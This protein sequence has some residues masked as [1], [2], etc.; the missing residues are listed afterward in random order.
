MNIRTTIICLALLLSSCL[1]FGQ[2][3]D[4]VLVADQYLQENLETLKLYPE[5]IEGYKVSSLTASKHNKATHLYL[6]QQY[7]GIEVFN[8]IFNL[9]IL[10]DG[11]VA[12]YGNRFLGQLYKRI[13]T[14]TPQISMEEA[15]KSFIRQFGI[16]SDAS[17]RMM[18]QISPTEATFDHVGLAL[19]PIQVKLVYQSLKNK[20]VHLAWNISFYQ[21]DAQHWWNARLDAID[22][23]V[24]HY[25][26]QVVHCEFGHMD[27][28]GEHHAI[29]AL[30]AAEWTTTVN[31]SDSAKYNV[32][33]LLVESPNHGDRALVVAPEDPLVSPFGWHDTD[34]EEGAEYTITRG[35]NVHA[36]HDIFSTNQSNGDEPDGGDSLC[37]DFELDLSVNRPY[38]QIDP[39]VTN[40]FYWNNLMHDVWYHYGFDEAS[41]NFQTTNYTGEGDGGDEVRAEAL[42]GSGTN[43]A[44]FAT[45]PEGSNPRMQ[46]Y[47]WGGQLPSFSGATFEVTSPDEVA[48]AY[49]FAPAGFGGDLPEGDDVLAGQV[50]L[51]DDGVGVTSDACDP[52]VNGAELEGNIAMIDRGECEFGFKCLAAEQAGAIAVIVCNNV[53]D[54]VFTMGAGAV[55]GQVTIP[56]IMVG[57]EDCNILKMGLPELTVEMGEPTL[58]VPQ[59]GPTGR[60]SDLDNGVIVHEYTHGISNRLTAG[61]QQS[62]CLSNF[63][64]AG[65]GWSDWYAL[66]MT[67]TS[68]MTAEQP[69]GI[70]TYASGQPPTGDGI[71]THPYSRDMDVNPHTFANIN[72][73][74]V[75]HGVGS[76]W[77]VMIWDLFWNLVDE[78]GYDEDL[79]YGTGGNNMAMQLVTDGLK[80]QPCNPTFTEARDAIL[81]ADMINYDGE[82]QC[83][84]WE[85]FARRGLGFSAENGGDEA[86][87]LP[88]ACLFIFQVAKTGPEE[89]MAGD[90]ITYELEIING[91]SENIEDGIVTDELPEGTSLLEG[92]S[93]CDI[94]N[95][96][97]I[98]TFN[99]G[100]VASGDIINCSYQV[101]VDPTPASYIVLDDPVEAGIP[102]WDF[103]TLVGD[104]SWS[105]NFSITNSDPFSLFAENIDTQS[106]Q[107][108]VL[109]EPVQLNGASPALTF[110]HYYDTEANWDGGVVEI[111]TN[112]NDWE[113]L[114]EHMIQNGYD[115]PLNDNPESPL[116]GRPAFNGN[117]GDWVQTAID[118]SDYSG[119]PVLVRFRFGTDGAVGADGWYLDDFRFYGNYRAIT[120]IACVEDVEQTRCSEI[121]TVIFGDA[122]S[123]VGEVGQA[124]RL[125][126]FPNPNK[127]SFTVQLDGGQP[128]AANLRIL[129]ISGQQLMNTQ[130][131]TFINQEINLSAY[132]AGMYLVQLVTEKGITTRKVVVE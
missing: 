120:N 104:A 10:E 106:D 96:N 122:P 112:G 26:D 49:E 72:N 56:A 51:A 70:G 129:S 23:K 116:S 45:P 39:L 16:A 25:F 52:I 71:R 123:S 5:D 24:L 29:Q 97:G 128:I 43:N 46:M 8:A 6:Q 94:T 82:N 115:G 99:L 92:S 125:L 65:E 105:G 33:P 34:G 114:G 17:V 31:N 88:P 27:C 90:T 18:E 20:K 110:W 67:T 1:L 3:K 76:V 130:Y 83:L 101:V 131:D 63:E 100:D 32:Y 58:E 119:M 61:A 66:V 40:L 111:S 11:K 55:G 15:V 13:N 54:G 118:L 28:E 81:Q 44:N 62:G 2:V 14:T 98:L 74:S 60:S 57:L 64:Q 48:G 113:D 77:C 36:Y 21:L 12:S 87:D 109:T 47:L 69:R 41:G 132:G 93:D 68:E 85:T 50:V 37:F 84:I 78:Y 79:Y 80:F 75:P 35:N 126:V 42:D 108:V 38:T 89:A 117:S 9:N 102:N 95:D 103:E 91:R 19:E 7:E 124:E 22:G 107:L 59:P 53:D 73:E 127:G 121:S 86:F 4:P 30:P